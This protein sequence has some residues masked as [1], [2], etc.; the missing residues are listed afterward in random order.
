[1]RPVRL[2]DRVAPYLGDPSPPSKLLA[3]PTATAVPFVVV[4]LIS[5]RGQPCLSVGGVAIATNVPSGLSVIA[6]PRTP[7]PAP[8]PGRANTRIAPLPALHTGHVPI[9]EQ[10]CGWRGV[11]FTSTQPAK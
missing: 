9:F 5:R 6:A 1:M 8:S 3:R 7:D 10:H 2:V 4:R 11:P